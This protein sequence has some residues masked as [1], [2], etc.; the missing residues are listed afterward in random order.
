MAARNTAEQGLRSLEVLW[1][2]S[3]GWPTE[4]IAKRLGITEETV[5]SYR[6]RIQRA[7]NL[8][9]AELRTWVQYL[10]AQFNELP[11]DEQSIG[12]H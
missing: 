6:N 10:V 9:R 2:D 7:L 8:D 4:A 11:L 1:L 3:Q 5:R 12:E